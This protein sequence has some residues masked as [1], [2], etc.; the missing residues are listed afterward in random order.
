MTPVAGIS[1]ADLAELELLQARLPLARPFTTRLATRTHK[2]VLL[3]RV[4]LADGCEG[5]GECAAEPDP[6]VSATLV[7]LRVKKARTWA[8]DVTEAAREAS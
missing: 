7:P 3:V 2:E 6:T 8:D 5:W 1:A 4:R